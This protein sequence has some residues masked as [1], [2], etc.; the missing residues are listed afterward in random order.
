MAARINVTAVRDCPVAEIRAVMSEV[1]RLACAGPECTPVGNQLDVREHGGWAWFATSVWGFSSGDLNRGLCTLARP[2]LQLTTS[3][4][5]RWY[6]PLTREALAGGMDLARYAAKDHQRHKLRDEAEA[7]AVVELASRDPHLWN[8]KVHRKGQ[9][10]WSESD[11][12]GHLLKVFFR[13][14]FAAYWDVAAH[15][16]EAA[17]QYR[18]HRDMQRQMRRAGA[19]AARR[20]AA[21]HDDEVLLQGKCGPHWRSDFARLKELE[22]ETREK[23]DTA[24]AGLGFPHAGD[25]VAKKQRDIVLRT[26]ASRDGMSYGILMA[27]RTMSLGYEFFSRFA[28]GSRLTTTT[29]GTVNSQPE[30]KVDYRTHPGREPGVDQADFCSHPPHGRRIVVLP[31]CLFVIHWMIL[32]RDSRATGQCA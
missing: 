31:S 7:K 23:T 13:H 28:D 3:D 2:A 32:R 15:D 9:T 5:D 11:M 20:R 18:E 21:P 24:L 4:G 10:V 22:Q 8:S 19:E 14:R 27:K 1:I 25:L 12:V 17:R 6:P 29:N 30:L 26:Y 16:R